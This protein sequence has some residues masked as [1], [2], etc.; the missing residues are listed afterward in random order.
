MIQQSSRHSSP[1]AKITAL[2]PI[3]NGMEYLP[4]FRANLGQLFDLD[5][6]VIVIDDNSNDGTLEF[7]MSWAREDTRL[8]VIKNSGSGLVDALNMGLH[9]AR[10]PWIARFDVDDKYSLNR[11]SIQRLHLHESLAALFSDYEFFSEDKGSLGR[12]YSALSPKATA[13]SLISSQRTAHPSVVF[14][15][16][17]AIQVGGYLAKDFP[18]EDLSLWLRL[19]GVGSIES[20]PDLLLQYRISTNSITGQNRKMAKEKS[21]N[22]IHA[23]LSLR[24][25]FSYSIAHLSDTVKFYSGTNK[26]NCRFVLH[27][28]DL[29]IGEKIYGFRISDMR[30]IL[31]SVMNFGIISFSAGVLEIRKDYVRRRNF[32]SNP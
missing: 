24:N 1:N 32:R 10:H 19:H 16:E 15:R 21:M 13:L 17:L 4:E 28:R 3:R 12:V 20:V 7:L 27:V 2:V 11:I 18:A 26:G 31:F 23:D 9:A 8:R 6:E 5:D 29:I 25:A 14:N 22:L 30:K